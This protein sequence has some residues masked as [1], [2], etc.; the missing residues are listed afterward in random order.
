[1]K[2][3]ETNVTK[4][5]ESYLEEHPVLMDVIQ[6]GIVNYS[7]LAREIIEEEEKRGNELSLG[8][9][10]MALLRITQEKKSEK[11]HMEKKLKKIIGESVIQ[12]QSDLAMITIERGKIIGRMKELSNLM[13]DARFFELTQGVDIFN[14]LVSREKL[15]DVIKILGKEN[16]LELMEGQT[17]IILTS[18]EENVKTP[19]FIYL[20]TS[21]LS[22]GG[23]NITEIISCHKDTI[24]V[25]DRK[26]AIRAYGILENFILRM[27]E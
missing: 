3:S 1:M 7:A 9:V 5:V 12:L 6:R 8:A 13:E 2:K 4:I 24:F 16:I 10:K 22:Y 20:L 14:V 19:G 11:E 27:R 21:V 15:R 26:D 17:A 23:I 25:F 18:P